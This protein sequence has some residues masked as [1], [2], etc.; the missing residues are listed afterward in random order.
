MS[1]ALEIVRCLP[2]RVRG[3]LTGRSL[4]FKGKITLVLNYLVINNL[5]KIIKIF[6]KK[7][8]KNLRNKILVVPLQRV[9]QVRFSYPINLLVI[10]FSVI[11]YVVRVRVRAGS[12]DTHFFI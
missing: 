6:R 12:V 8:K 9:E 5:N 4:N 11:N 7:F 1:E 3:A 2:P 10:S